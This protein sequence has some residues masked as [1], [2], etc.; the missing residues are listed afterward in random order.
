[1]LIALWSAKGGVGTS[2]VTAALAVAVAQR[3]GRVRVVD[4]C[5]DHPALFGRD[6]DPELG[7]GDWL[8]AGPDAPADGLDRLALDVAP[9]VE[10]LPFGSSSPAIGSSA[11]AALLTALEGCS[12]P[13]VADVGSSDDALATA[14]REGASR[15]VLVVRTCYT[16]LRRSVNHGAASDIDALV[17]VED[18][19]RAL[20][21]A[22]LEAVL[23]APVTATVP[24]RP[25][26]A[27]VVDAG[28]LAVRPP[29]ALLRPMTHLADALRVDSEGVVA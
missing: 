18:P 2:V 8:A 17:V 16:A 15:S 6:P 24:V 14:V 9:G 20:R 12:M 25:S 3:H 26:I 21:A 13:C 7:L 11:A 28:V 23:S 22:D 10:M 5:G 27:Q 4:A 29:A 19:G 1:M